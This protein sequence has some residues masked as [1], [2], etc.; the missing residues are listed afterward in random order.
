MKEIKWYFFRLEVDMS[1]NVVEIDKN[2]YKAL[3]EAFGQEV[4]REK[5]NIFLVSAIETHLEK[6][7]REILNFEKK[8]GL[9]FMEFEKKW[10]EGKVENKHSHEVEGD[11]IDWEM[12]EME[13][14]ELLLALSK[15]QKFKE[16]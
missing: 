7:I 8:Y 16:S 9:T 2:L 10:D 14:K 1:S 4:L 13:K 6:Y 3:V 5:I 11:F 15:L 12:M